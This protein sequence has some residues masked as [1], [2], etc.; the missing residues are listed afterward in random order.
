MYLINYTVVYGSV[1]Y[2]DSKLLLPSSPV[3]LVGEN[4]VHNLTTDLDGR[5]NVKVN[6][7]KFV[8]HAVWVGQ[9]KAKTKKI[10]LKKGDSLVVNFY[11]EPTDEKHYNYN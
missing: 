11:L 7:D 1:R 2:L 5:F 8:I 6:P 9:K 3:N 10:R 4:F